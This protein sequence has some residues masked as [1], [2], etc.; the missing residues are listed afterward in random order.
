MALPLS[1]V[2]CVVS[3]HALNI[4]NSPICR[5]R[6]WPSEPP[7]LQ[8][9]KQMPSKARS[10]WFRH[11]NFWILSKGLLTKSATTLSIHRTLADVSQSD[12]AEFTFNM[13][14]AMPN[15]KYNCQFFLFCFS[16]RYVVNKWRYPGYVQVAKDGHLDGYVQ[17]EVREP[18][19]IWKRSWGNIQH[20]NDLI[21]TQCLG[22]HRVL[23]V[24]FKMM[25]MI[26]IYVQRIVS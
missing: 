11:C 23:I 24:D 10:S 14:S 8:E 3:E 25:M 5:A 17:V 7:K 1:L 20:P 13:S 6:D 18:R 16:L 15:V 21:F 22:S 9:S 4:L 19:S 2:L 26:L 12:W